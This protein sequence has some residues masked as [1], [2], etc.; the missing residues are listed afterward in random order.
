MDTNPGQRHCFG[1]RSPNDRRWSIRGSANQTREP[2]GSVSEC[3]LLLF[4]GRRAQQRAACHSVHASD[5][6]GLTF[7][8]SVPLTTPPPKC[9]RGLHGHVKVSPK[10]GAVYVPFNQ[11]NGEGSVI[12]SLDNCITWTIRHV[13][14]GGIKTTPSI[15]FRIR[16]VHGRCQRARLLHHC[17]SRHRGGGSYF[18]RSRRLPGRISVTWARFMDC[19]TSGTRRR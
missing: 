16:P 18:R 7:G 19:R 2:A 3:G 1:C 14:S 4:A 8:P 15:S 13:E 9:L 6:G 11:C 17:E 10:D 12:V 5:D